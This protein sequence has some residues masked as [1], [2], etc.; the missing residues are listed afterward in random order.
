MNKA[1]A[2]GLVEVRV[3]R[4]CVF[5]LWGQVIE[6]PAEIVATAEADGF[7]D[8]SEES[9]AYAKSLGAKAES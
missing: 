7:V 5:G 1:K 8:S 6:L 3:L 4:D 9:V 2:S